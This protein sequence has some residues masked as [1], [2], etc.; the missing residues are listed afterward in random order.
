MKK[1]KITHKVATPYHP[2][3]NGQDELANREIKQIL[4]KMVNPNR[5]YWS[6]RLNDALWAYRTAFKMSLKMLPYWLVYDKP[7]GKPYHLLVE[8]EHK[9]FWAIKVFNS[10]LG[11]A[12]YVQKLQL[13]EL[14]ELRND[15]YENSRIKVNGLHLFPGKVKLK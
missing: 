5:K 7:C 15:V 6:L 1:Y 3:T 2:Q 13:N 9:S 11:D 8:L 4:E 14:E 12:D 10:N